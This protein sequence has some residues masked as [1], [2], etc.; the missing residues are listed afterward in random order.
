MIL[1]LILYV[2][3]ISVYY[4]KLWLLITCSHHTLSPVRRSRWPRLAAQPRVRFGL[5]LFFYLNSS[6]YFYYSL[7]RSNHK[8]I[9]DLRDSLLMSS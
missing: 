3:V 7:F 9:L 4:H 8:L 5:E 1:P 2:N 6:D